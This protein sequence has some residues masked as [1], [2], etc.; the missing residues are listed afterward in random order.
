MINI[1]LLGSGAF[2]AAFQD[3]DD[4]LKFLKSRFSY[5]EKNKGEFDSNNC[6]RNQ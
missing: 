5:D 2:G 6:S 3:P 4:P 1:N